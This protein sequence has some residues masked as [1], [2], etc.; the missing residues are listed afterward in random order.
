MRHQSNV[1]TPQIMGDIIEQ[2]PSDHSPPSHDEIRILDSLF[3]EQQGIVNKLLSEFK[4]IIIMGILFVIFSLPTLDDLIIK[5]I[6]IASTSKY[7]LVSIKALLFMVSYFVLQ[8]L[9]LVR[10]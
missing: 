4:N 8:N 6:N 2:L 3:K 5:F 7:I 10:A 1:D 9:Y